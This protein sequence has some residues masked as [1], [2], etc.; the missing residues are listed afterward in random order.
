MPWILNTPAAG[1]ILK[2]GNIKIAHIEMSGYANQS[3]QA[4]LQDAN[5]REICTLTGAADLE[6][7]RSGKVGW[8]QGLIYQSGPLVGTVK[9]YIE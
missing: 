3:D 4:V 6:E 9:V 1:V 2:T 5:G 7:V 8:V